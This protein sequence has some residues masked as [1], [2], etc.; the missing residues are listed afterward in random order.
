MRFFKITILTFL[1]TM[2]VWMMAGDRSQPNLMSREVF[3]DMEM[4]TPPEME[5]DA[6]VRVE[7]LLDSEGRPYII[8]IWS[9]DANIMHMIRKMINTGTELEN[10]GDDQSLAITFY[11]NNIR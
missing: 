5:D 1:L 6:P 3:L 2:P 4:Q 10:G 7:Y 9:N 8:S 11:Y